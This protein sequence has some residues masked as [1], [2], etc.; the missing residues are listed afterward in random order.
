MRFRSL[1]QAVHAAADELL[2]R[3]SVP[4]QCPDLILRT[5]DGEGNVAGEW[6][7][8]IVEMA[9]GRW[10]IEEVRQVIPPL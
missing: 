3:R 2:L 9:N 4:M 8:E 1:R 6:R 10:T 5:Y 7:A